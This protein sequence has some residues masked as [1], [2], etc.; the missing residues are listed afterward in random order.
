MF[1]KSE[2]KIVAVECHHR[3]YWGSLSIA[4]RLTF[5]YAI[6]TF[7]LLV[8]SSMGLFW[9]LASNLNREDTTSLADKVRSLCAQLAHPPVNEKNGNV[10]WLASEFSNTLVENPRKVNTSERYHRFFY[11]R[12]LNSRGRVIIE[13]PGANVLQNSGVYPPPAES[14]NNGKVIKWRFNDGRSY[15]VQTGHVYSGPKSWIVQ[16]ALDRSEEERLLEEYRRMLFGVQAIGL[17]LSI[18]LGYGI[19]RRGMRPLAEMT[20]VLRKIRVPHLQP[21]VAAEGWP[22]ELTSLALTFDEM[23]NHLEESFGRI[24]RF[25]SDLAHELRTPLNSL[26]GE[27][28][29]ALSRE[30]TES[31][32]RRVIESS[33]EEYERLS[34]VIDS[35]LFLARAENTDMVG[36]YSNFNART[37]ADAVLQFYEALAEE[38]GVSLVCQGDATLTADPDLFRRA[39]SN[40]ISNALQYTPSGG[41]IIL[42]ILQMSDGSVNVNVSDTGEGIEQE[43]LPR[44]FERFYRSDNARSL[45]PDGSGLGLAIVKSIMDIHGGRVSIQSEL[46]VGTTTTLY[47]PPSQNNPYSRFSNSITGL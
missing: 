32:Y 42:T 37:E 6:C 13:T 5:L 20:E 4:G 18:F 47:F 7:I 11:T 9:F 46:G 31:E 19:A 12:L 45:H 41:E 28:E 23:M 35:L 40:L 14:D 21:R 39:L 8:L 15:L 3:D 30:R 36:V 2:S 44:V 38:K 34:H 33:L 25:S 16:V 22:S 29:V 26:R 10:A 1:S 43:H 24:T 17:I 27:A